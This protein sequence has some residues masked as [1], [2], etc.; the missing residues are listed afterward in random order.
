MTRDE[1]SE[2]TTRAI[3]FAFA[4]LRLIA[5]WKIQ[6]VSYSDTASYSTLSFLGHAPRLWTAPLLFHYFNSG[7]TPVV[8]QAL[9][10]IACWSTLAVT[11]ATLVEDYRARIGVVFVICAIGTSLAVTNWDA[12]VLSDSITV[13]LTVLL[14]AAWLSEVNTPNRTSLILLLVTT[15][16]WTFTRQS[17]V[18]V[19]DLIALVALVSVWWAKD[20][21]RRLLLALALVA[22]SLWGHVALENDHTIATINLHAVLVDRI[23]SVPSYV[24]WFHDHGLPAVPRKYAAVDPTSPEYDAAYTKWLGEH[25][26]SLYLRF[27]LTHPAYTAGSPWR[28]VLPLH[29]TQF[30]GPPPPSMLG[31]A[32]VYGRAR[33]VLPAVLEDLLVDSGNGGLLLF[34]VAGV[35][36]A[37]AVSWRRDGFDSRWAVPLVILGVDVAQIVVVWHGSPAELGRHSLALSVSARVALWILAFLVVDR[38]LSP[39]EAID[40]VDADAAVA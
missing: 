29:E 36:V 1:L 34:L 31:M 25:G 40:A 8:V 19:G 6:P 37:V 5:V 24:R 17:N 10:G 13:S 18:L 7:A 27:L 14:V 23:S 16:L 4:A 22:V 21:A 33:P 32:E 15:V 39:P 12:T 38:S 28:D 30:G 26:E 9:I 11:A 2:W 20:R 35:G 3:L